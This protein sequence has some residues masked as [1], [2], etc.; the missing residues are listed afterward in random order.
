MFQQN[1]IF[2]TNF[3]TH[4]VIYFRLEGV[5]KSLIPSSNDSQL[6]T[7]ILQFFDSSKYDPIICNCIVGVP[8]IRY[9]HITILTILPNK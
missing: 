6:I 4:K 2:Q 5:I 1:V 9:I 7:L 8:I 3:K